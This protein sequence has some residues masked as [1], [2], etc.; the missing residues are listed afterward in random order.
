[1]HATRAGII[2]LLLK[3]G[4]RDSDCK[5][6]YVAVQAKDDV[7]IA[8]LLALKSHLD[9]ENKINKKAGSPGEGRGFGGLSHQVFPNNAVMINWHGQQCLE[10]IRPQWLS[11]AAISLNPK[12]KLHPRAQPVALHAITRIDVSNSVLTELPLIIFQLQ[13]VRHLNFAQ[14]KLE[15]LPSGVF[16]CPVLEELLLQDNR[17]TPTVFSLVPLASPVCGFRLDFLPETLLQLPS[18]TVLDVSNNKLQHLPK[19]M[20][21]APKLKEINASF[22]LLRD[23][24]NYFTKSLSRSTEFS[25]G[26]SYDFTGESSAPPPMLEVK[27]ISLSE[28]DSLDDARMMRSI[29]LA[30]INITP[31]ELDHQ[32]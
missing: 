4:A 14:N 8:K 20:W 2:D 18:L 17:Y 19:E 27:N 13:S 11:E 10:Y 24:P 23:L 7:I 30:T 5:A 9:P 1:M 25:F 16:N 26:S 21:T 15:R 12:M 31:Q 22:N 28:D 3:H 6:L 29:Q 32:R